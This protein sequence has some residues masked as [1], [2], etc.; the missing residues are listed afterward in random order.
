M[1]AK[2]ADYFSSAEICIPIIFGIDTRFFSLPTAAEGN[3]YSLQ[4]QKINE[5]IIVFGYRIPN[6]YR[7]LAGAAP[8]K[9]L[10]RVTPNAAPRCVQLLKLL[11]FQ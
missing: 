6:E 9:R 7:P 2:K 11:A 4:K 5:I 8:Q 3:F 10:Q 1:L